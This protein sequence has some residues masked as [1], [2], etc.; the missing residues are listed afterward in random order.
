MVTA[1]NGDTLLIYR[2]GV[3][4]VEEYPDL[5]LIFAC[6][7]ARYHGKA[8]IVFNPWRQEWELPSG[9]IEPGEAPLA[10]ALRE[11]YE[12][13]G[14]SVS[15]LTYAGLAL[16]RLHSGRLEL[17]AMYRCELDQLQ[18]FQLNDES[19]KM[20]LWGAQTEV[21]EEINALTLKLIEL[22]SQQLD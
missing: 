3:T 14:Q 7:V 11:L 2:S 10:A 17:G 18:P 9:L 12:E 13:S 1:R 8:L 20:L 15:T 6:V 16:I 21:A 4:T 19:S 22:V 5:P